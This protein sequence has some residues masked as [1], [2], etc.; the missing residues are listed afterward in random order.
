M[1][2]PF[3]SRVSGR[4]SAFSNVSST[5][6]ILNALFP[7]SV[8]LSEC[9]SFCSPCSAK[10]FSKNSDKL[11][12]C[13]NCSTI[14]RKFYSSVEFTKKQWPKMLAEVI[15]P[16]TSKKSPSRGFSTL[17]FLFSELVLLLLSPEHMF[18]GFDA[19]M[20]H[21][22]CF[23]KNFASVCF[24]QTPVFCAIYCTLTVCPTQVILGLFCCKTWQK[25]VFLST[26]LR[27]FCFAAKCKIFVPDRKKIVH[28]SQTCISIS[29][30]FSP[31]ELV[32]ALRYI[33][34]SFRLVLFLLAVLLHQSLLL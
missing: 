30:L 33:V 7:Y 14:V 34:C 31:P 15:G 5:L 1:V 3:C 24:L 25:I 11:L 12:L 2:T 4:V 32:A 17:V 9:N 27:T 29:R 18:H 6:K 16:N 10:K 26:L 28:C 19:L 23:D 20:N 8:Q 22:F 21:F 13:V